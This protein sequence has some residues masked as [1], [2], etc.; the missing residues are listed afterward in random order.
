MSPFEAA[1]NIEDALDETG[2]DP[3]DLQPGGSAEQRLGRLGLTAGEREQLAPSAPSWLTI[4]IPGE[5]FAQPRAR[6]AVN[7]K[8]GRAFVY[9]PKVAKTWKATAQSHM[10]SVRFPGP[11]ESIL[12][13]PVELHITA[14]FT[15]PK[16]AHRKREPVRRS[17]HTKR[18]D[19]DNVT[20][21]VKDAAKGVLWFDDAQVSRT[22]CEKI[23]AAQGE[24]PYVEVQVRA[25]EVRP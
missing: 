20:K 14:V 5:P 11:L 7:Q 9:D 18:P 6:A 22:T 24:A 21:A 8:T 2:Y 15:C 10:L 4:R 17:W 1:R 3:F 25:L 16:S 13:G 12:A 19:A 23:V